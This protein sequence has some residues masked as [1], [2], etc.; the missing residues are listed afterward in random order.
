[1][2]ARKQTEFTNLMRA[3]LGPDRWARLM[4]M[5]RGVR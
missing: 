5:A 2:D 4:A 3:R 1:M